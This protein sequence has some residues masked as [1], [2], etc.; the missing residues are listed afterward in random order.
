M[1][2]K[3][4]I[5]A[6]N[7]EQLGHESSVTLMNPGGKLGYDYDHEREREREKNMG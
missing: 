7:Y 1:R 4:E 3:A 2:V 5:S 6:M